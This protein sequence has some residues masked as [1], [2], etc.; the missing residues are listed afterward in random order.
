MGKYV[1]ESYYFVTWAPVTPCPNKASNK[2]NTR[3]NAKNSSTVKQMC[4]FLCSNKMFF[5]KNLVF[6]ISLLYIIL[7]AYKCTFSLLRK[8]SSELL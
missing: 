1:G 4:D 2:N 8:F 5:F 7:Y 6:A 3:K